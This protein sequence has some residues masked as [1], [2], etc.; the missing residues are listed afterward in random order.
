LVNALDFFFITYWHLQDILKIRAQLCK[1]ALMSEILIVDDVS[2]KFDYKRSRTIRDRF[3][4]QKDPKESFWAVKNVSFT[5]NSGESLALLGPNGSGKSSLLKVI[6]GIHRPTSGQVKRRGRLGALLELGAGFHP[7]LTGRENI[8]LNGAI[9]G[10]QKKEIE[11]ILDTVVDFSGLAPFIDSPVKTFSSGMYVR[12]GFAIAVHTDPDLLIVDEVLSV[13]DEA[14]QSICLSKI[15]EIQANGSSIVLVTH[16]MQSALE[17]TQ[18][19]I[20]LSHGKMVFQGT[21][22][23]AIIAYHEHQFDKFAPESEF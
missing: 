6:G 9:L 12:L 3:T 15:R 22:E 21:A 14:F 23:E 18:Q 16:N 8:F 13:G 2:L 20:V 17:F 11:K 7:E 5:L 4:R 1:G 19:G 10:L